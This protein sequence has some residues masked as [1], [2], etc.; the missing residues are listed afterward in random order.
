MMAVAL[1]RMISTLEELAPGN[2]VQLKRSKD[3]SGRGAATVVA[4]ASRLYNMHK[5]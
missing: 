5:N 1:S 2:K 3:G 4:V